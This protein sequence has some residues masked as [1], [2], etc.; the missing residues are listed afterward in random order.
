M[1][2]FTQYA[3]AALKLVQHHGKLTPTQC[4]SILMGKKTKFDQ[5]GLEMYHG[6]AKHIAKHDIHRVLGRLTADDALKE[7][8]VIYR[9]SGIATQYLRLGPK[10]HSF[11]SSERK[12]V[13]AT[14][15]KGESDQNTPSTVEK[16]P[17]RI[18]AQPTG[19]RVG[20]AAENEVY[21]TRQQSL[22]HEDCLRCTA[23]NQRGVR[24]DHRRGHDGC[25]QSREC[26][27]T[28][29]IVDWNKLAPRA[30]F[31][32]G[33]TAKAHYEPLLNRDYGHGHCGD[34][35]RKRQSLHDSKP[36]TLETEDRNKPYARNPYNLEDGEV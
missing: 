9:S 26:F 35:S 27:E 14:T 13:L 23:I 7:E 11:L 36:K 1:V 10:A 22:L 24:E 2:D 33:A 17:S 28:K 21:G 32:D 34:A 5:K 3:I 4:A 12:L 15:S 6:I 20:F 29:P 25:R 30:G 16:L 19:R 31:E 8:N 18:T